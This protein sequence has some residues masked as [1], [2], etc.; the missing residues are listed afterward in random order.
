MFLVSLGQNGKRQGKA[1][2]PE[3]VRG[4]SLSVLPTLSVKRVLKELLNAIR[5]KTKG[6]NTA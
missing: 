3:K 5:I 2:S 6:G 1:L 4:D